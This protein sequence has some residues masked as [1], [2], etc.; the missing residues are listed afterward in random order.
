MVPM[1]AGHA[2]VSEEEEKKSRQKKRTKE[3]VK[4][5]RALGHLINYICNNQENLRVKRA[6]Y[7]H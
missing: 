5:L 1:I 6:I 3:R 2:L 4:R 7:C